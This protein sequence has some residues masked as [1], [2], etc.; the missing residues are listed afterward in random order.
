MT[1]RIITVLPYDPQWADDFRQQAA[2]LQGALSEE[3]VAIHHIGSTAVPGLAAKPV[4]D[5]LLAVRDLN[6]LDRF[7]CA[8]EQLSYQPRGE[9]GI[10]GRRYF[11]KGGVRRTHHLHAFVTGSEH[12]IRHLAFR[13]YLRR[14][15]KVMA[16]YA[17]LKYQ[18]AEVCGGDAAAY[19]Q[20]K[21]E[22]IAM[23]QLRAMNE[24]DSSVD[25]CYSGS[26]TFR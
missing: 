8:F 5:M 13:D 3:V 21:N 9:N 19:S 4:I 12:I 1:G 2:S 26:G 23:H 22:F 6:V 24:W 10:A 11:T 20:S 25:S 15:A 18:A 14:H 17:Q 7:N 16:E